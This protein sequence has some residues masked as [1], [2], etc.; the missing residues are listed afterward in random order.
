[1]RPSRRGAALLLLPALLSACASGAT[2]TLSP[3]AAPTPWGVVFTP[4]PTVD[5][6]GGP[7]ATPALPAAFATYVVRSGDTLSS[8][9]RAFAV[10]ADDLGTWNV[11]RYP[12][13]ATAPDIIEPGWEL[14]VGGPGHV[15]TPTAPATPATPAPVATAN[16][17]PG[18]T[19]GNHVAPAAETTYRAIPN[20]GP[21]VALTFDM[22][23]RMEPA[24]DILA[25]LIEHEVCATI[26]ATGAMS[27]TAEGQ[28]ALA[29]VRDHPQLFEMGNHTMHHCDLVRGG[30]GSPR[31]APCE[32]GRPT[33]ER[34]AAELADAAA[35]IVA[36]TGQD[37][38]P[39]WRPPYGSIDADVLA[40]AA[41]AGY[42]ATFLWDI[43]TA[44][45]RPIADGGPTAEQ[46]AAR[47]VTDAVNG[48][49]V[50]FHLGGYETL[51]ALRLLVPALRDRGFTLT[52]LSDMAH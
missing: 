19:A 7:V 12:S 31:K 43:D 27:R 32:G 39:Y 41:A 35:V 14:V 26:F 47:V 13:L 15:T 22:G 33:P 11:D 44:D 49:N 36:A 38:R 25:F 2:S 46:I 16:P 51:D 20:A 24:V 21:R 30:G 45:W 50:L 17:A 9:G 1:M 29:I 34:I 8:I 18:C 40:A 5:A 42:T 6:E 3:S 48:S 52:S 4:A 37:P 28:A 10:S 23:G